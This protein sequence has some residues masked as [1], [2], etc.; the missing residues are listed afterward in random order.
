MVLD[1]LEAELDN[2]LG[3]DIPVVA[4]DN[5]LEELD[6]LVAEPDNLVAEADSWPEAGFDNRFAV[7]LFGTALVGA[8]PVAEVPLVGVGAGVEVWGWDFAKSKA[9]LLPPLTKQQR[10][11]L[12]P[13]S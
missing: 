8:G 5:R 13:E 3:E 12:L 11:F 4:S 6:N 9:P 7:E 1:S 2:R 10:W